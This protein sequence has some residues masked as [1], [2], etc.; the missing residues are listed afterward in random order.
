[1]TEEYTLKRFSVLN[2]RKGRELLKPW[3]PCIRFHITNLLFVSLQRRNAWLRAFRTCS[4][5]MTCHHWRLWTCLLACPASSKTPAT[6]HRPCWMISECARA[7]PSSVTSCSGTVW[8][9]RDVPRQLR[10]RLMNVP[11]SFFLCVCMC[12]DWSRPRRM[13]QKMHWR[14][15]LTWLPAWPHT[16]WLS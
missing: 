8:T 16:V 3:F 7:T 10:P 2:K 11:T 1:M 13:N 4:S 5:L 9:R 6:C 14:T 12:P 15:L